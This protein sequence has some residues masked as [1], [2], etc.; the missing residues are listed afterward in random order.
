[1][2]VNR[3]RLAWAFLVAACLAPVS[4]GQT[5]LLTP[6]SE[7]AT[8][9]TEVVATVYFLNEGDAP[10]RIA[11]P[12]A[13]IG[14]AQWADGGSDVTL[15][16]VTD[17]EARDV[18]PGGFVRVPYRFT[19]PPAARGQ[20]T[21]AL[22]GGAAPAAVLAVTPPPPGE[23]P[24]SETSAQAPATSPDSPAT[25]QPRDEPRPGFAEYVT[26]HF[27]PYEP[28]YFLIGAEEPNGK[29]QISLKYR[30]FNDDASFVRAVPPLGGLH[31]AY[32]QTS[33]WDLE[34]ASSPF[35]DNSYR[36]ELMVSYADLLRGKAAGPI[37]QLGFQAGLQHES[38]GQ[39]GL[40]SRSV[41]YLYVR[42]SFT[43]GATPGEEDHS[44]VGGLFLS[45][46]PRLHAYLGDDEDNPDIE[47]FRG[48]GDLL[49]VLGQRRGLQL[50]AIGRIG[51]DFDKGS[52]QLD[53]TYP[54]RPLLQ[55]NVDIFLHGQFFT[56]YGESLL[57][58][59]ESDT[60]FRVGVSLI[61]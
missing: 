54:L 32:S 33:F 21:L 22:A 60:T 15:A 58:Y 56:G 55:D 8:A 39:D 44:R 13:L 52:L 51:S 57:L 9:G 24:S 16:R 23:P 25:A 50:A 30:I 40:D 46:A 3:V 14:D 45:V 43:F 10:R 35:F 36:P 42:P 59:D 17:A 6:P 53:L 7:S 29:F 20:M 49:L 12:A 27:S 19:V 28:M 11:P 41:N 18:P 47:E 26:Q 38:N 37:R 4:S 2:G 1:M 48:Y 34:S 5:V 61:R 31:F